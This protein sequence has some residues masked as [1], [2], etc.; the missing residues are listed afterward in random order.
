MKDFIEGCQAI[1]CQWSQIAMWFDITAAGVDIASS[2]GLFLMKRVYVHAREKRPGDEA[3]VD[4]VAI[5]LYSA[6]GSNCNHKGLVT[7][8]PLV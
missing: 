4:N 2:P 6:G 1:D 7:S 5:E 8:K 3:S